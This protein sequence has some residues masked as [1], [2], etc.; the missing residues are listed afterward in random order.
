MSMRTQS[1][2]SVICPVAVSFH[3]S[4]PSSLKGGQAM[5]RSKSLLLLVSLLVSGLQIFSP[6]AKGQKDNRPNHSALS[7]QRLR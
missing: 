6:P 1:N 5:N 3:L 7:V 4:Q 2:S